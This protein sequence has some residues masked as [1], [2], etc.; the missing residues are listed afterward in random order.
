MIRFW[1]AA[2]LCA[3]IFAICM[4]ALYAASHLNSLSS[5]WR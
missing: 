2:A 4:Y 5:L 1:F 3:A